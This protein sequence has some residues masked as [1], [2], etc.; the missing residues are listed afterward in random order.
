MDNEFAEAKLVIGI[1]LM[2]IAFLAYYVILNWTDKDA[3]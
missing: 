2:F 3:K 1:F